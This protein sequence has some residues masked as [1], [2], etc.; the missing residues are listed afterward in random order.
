MQLQTYSLYRLVLLRKRPT[1]LKLLCAVAVLLGLFLT[2]I[3]VL[4]GMDQ[5]SRNGNE[6]Y[7]AQ[8]RLGQLLWPLCFMFGFVSVYTPVISSSSCMDTQQASN[9]Q[10]FFL[11][12]GS[13]LRE[14][15]DKLIE[16]NLQSVT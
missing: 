9:M 8:S 16:E 4:T 15:A 7:L 6:A 14:H 5:D 2:L 12:E 10:I 1:L 11:E 13:N 3:P